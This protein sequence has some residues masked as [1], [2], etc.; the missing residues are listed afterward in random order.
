VGGLPVTD[1]PSGLKSEVPDA[2][3]PVAN[4]DH[5]QTD[6][7]AVDSVADLQYYWGQ[8][9]PHAFNGKPFTGVKRL[10]SYDSSAPGIPLCDGPS[11]GKATAFYCAG[12]DS[13]DWD[14]GP[15][16]TN[17]AGRFGP[18]AV[19]AALAHAMGYAIEQRGATVPAG[20]PPVLAEQQADCFAGSFFHY[21]ATNQSASLHF[22]VSTG[23]GLNQVM[24]AL[25]FLGDAPSAGSP[26]P[27]ATGS[28]LDRIAAFE[29]GFDT[30][31]ANCGQLQAKAITE[32]TSQTHFWDSTQEADLPL[33][34]ANL[35]LVETSLENVFRQTAAP[36][37]K[38]TT[39]PVPCGQAQ[40]TS[41]ATYCPRNNT[42]SVNVAQLGQIAG[43]P[44]AS[45]TNTGHGAFAAYADLASRYALSVENA[46]GLSLTDQNASLR[47]AC[48]VGAWSGLLVDDPI[49]Q[50]SPIGTFRIGPTD[51]DA[52]VA[53]LLNQ[54]GLVDANGSG[55]QVPSGF[56][57]VDAFQLGFGQ[58]TTACG[59][60]FN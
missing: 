3:L 41:A 38:L 24:S 20:S 28:A 45:G 1:G 36:L 60:Q 7:L 29:Y 43:S 25:S 47:T 4:S 17:L 37:P 27:D 35:G 39:N 42:I 40:P 10:V 23:D 52:I 19:P 14:R 31:P 33:T 16:L 12:D 21:A 44:Q 46:A 53:E 57:R 22:Q 15:F 9:F 58:G 54:N 26:G 13:L 59:A 30:A 56:A 55:Q 34:P 50:R 5:G 2:T 48:M 32:Q 11:S 18:L 49:G 51:V 6:K 8:A